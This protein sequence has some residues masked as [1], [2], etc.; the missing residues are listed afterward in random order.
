MPDN[1]GLVRI[2]A[3]T[4][5]TDKLLLNVLGTSVG[6]QMA[7]QS[8]ESIVTV[9]FTTATIASPM[10]TPMMPLRQMGKL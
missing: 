1:V 5:A 2:F 6:F 9:K 7:L 8:M 4:M 10:I 3:A